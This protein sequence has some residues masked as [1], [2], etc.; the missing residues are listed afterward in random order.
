M[1]SDN[2]DDPLCQ[3]AYV[4][5]AAHLMSLD[6]L[7]ALLDQ[8]RRKNDRL[9]ITGMLL[10]K[11]GSFLQVLEGDP[12][13]VRTLYQHIQRDERHIKVKTLF[14]EPVRARDF[15]QWSMGFQNLDGL[16]LARIDGYSDF[17]DNP[18]TA[19]AYF[20]DRTR[21]KKLLLLFRSKS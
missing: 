4:S 3:L 20:S 2:P 15:P 14:D 9:G 6:E 1:T 8:S 13:A 11:D 12:D 18:V 21:A 10:Y 17:F 19:R 5:S 16:D 7:T